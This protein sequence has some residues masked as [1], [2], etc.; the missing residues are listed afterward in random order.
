M[1]HGR[2]S[3][4]VKKSTYQYTGG[5]GIDNERVLV[6]TDIIILFEYH[7][8]T[9]QHHTT[10]HYHNRTRQNRTTGNRIVTLAQNILY[11]L[12]CFCSSPVA[13]RGQRNASIYHQ[14]SKS[15]AIPSGPCMDLSGATQWRRSRGKATRSTSSLTAHMYIVY[16]Y[17]MSMIAETIG[18]GFGGLTLEGEASTELVGSLVELLG[19]ERATE[20]QGDTLAEEDVVGKGGNTAVVDLD[21]LVETRRKQSVTEIT[22][23]ER[24]KE[25]VPWRRRRGQCGTCWRPR[26]RQCCWSWSSRWPWHRPRP[27]C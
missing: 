21:L 6:Y 17:G 13:R 27:G 15:R 18:R 3:L 7:Q 12:F 19:V 2:E 9:K 11:F 23:L 1:I 10:E 14:R 4:F 8:R 20:T 25:N 16:T 5:R 22:R 24:S 26:G